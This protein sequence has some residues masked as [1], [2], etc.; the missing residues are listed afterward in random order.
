[1]SEQ[2]GLWRLRIL[3]IAVAVGVWI[4]A[5]YLP[6]LQQLSVPQVTQVFRAAVSYSTPSGFM[7]LNAA[8]SVDVTLRGSEEV[9]TKLTDADIKVS[10]PFPPPVE[11]G[12]RLFA[13]SPSDVNTVEG[14]EVVSLDPNRLDL[15]VD[16]I[17]SR[18]LTVL[19][20]RKGEPGAG[21]TLGEV[22]VEPDRVEV[23]GPR[24]HVDQLTHVTTEAITLDFHSVTFAEEVEVLVDDPLVT[25]VAPR[26]VTVTVELAPPT[27]DISETSG[28]F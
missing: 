24:T 14:V 9:M 12:R 8:Q 26:V 1:M 6:R 20:N 10:V 18:E 4:F 19:W 27:I 23:R 25:I 7:V 13:L 28:L 5:S 3:S 17:V 2:N 16:E 22:T 11:A 21:A 15:L